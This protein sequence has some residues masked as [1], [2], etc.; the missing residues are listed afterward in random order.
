MHP[1]SLLSRVQE[2][3]CGGVFVITFLICVKSILP[4]SNK[5][6]YVSTS[7][8]GKALFFLHHKPGADGWG[9][10][11]GRRVFARGRGVQD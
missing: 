1:L 4:I 6:V 7:M 3:V 11:V 5:N 2:C 9:D 8:P 10:W